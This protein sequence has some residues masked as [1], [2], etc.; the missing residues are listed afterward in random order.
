MQDI[1][2]AVLFVSSSSQNCQP[3]VQ[4]VMQSNLPISVVRLD[5]AETRRKAMTNRTFPIREVPSLV[6][7][8][9]NGTRNLYT[10]RMKIVGWIQSHMRSQSQTPQPAEYPVGDDDDIAEFIDEDMVDDVDTRPKPKYISAADYKK[11][12][13]DDVLQEDEYPRKKK[14]KKRKH[15]KKRR[16][17]ED[18]DEDDGDILVI[19]DEDDEPTY[20]YPSHHRGGGD[21]SL[22]AAATSQREAFESFLDKH[23]TE[24]Y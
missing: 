22:S 19:G 17:H 16:T 13:K 14:R 23:K 11:P 4:Q 2:S 3:C 6:V 9:S 7:S 20:D 21:D 24:G 5:T 12:V 1:E 8:H 15:R 10:G 18:E